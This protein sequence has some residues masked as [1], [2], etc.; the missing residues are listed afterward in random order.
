MTTTATAETTVPAVETA[1]ELPKGVQSDAAGLFVM[2]DG[3]RIP[4]NAPGVAEIAGTPAE[5]ALAT[6][7]ALDMAIDA[8]VAARDAEK[9]VIKAVIGDK[10]LATLNGVP[11]ADWTWG[12]RT[13][14]DGAMVKALASAVWSAAARVTPTRPFN[15]KKARI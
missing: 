12:S 6:V 3:V 7:R 9:S 4:T 14:V 1:V 8:L 13:T 11:V 2:K 5:A 15:I 10:A